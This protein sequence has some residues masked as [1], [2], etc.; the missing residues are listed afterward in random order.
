MRTWF[1]KRVIPIFVVLSCLI[2]ALAVAAHK[3]P[4]CGLA[5]L[6]LDFPGVFVLGDEWE[7]KL[8]LWGATFAV[9]AFSQPPALLMALGLGCLFP[10]G[11]NTK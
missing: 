11:K 7:P 4:V 3:Y 1:K 6:P 5:L 2:A 8:G 10:L 9:W